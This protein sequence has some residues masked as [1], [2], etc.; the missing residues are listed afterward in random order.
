MNLQPPS[1]CAFVSGDWRFVHMR[2]LMCFLLH[3]RLFTPHATSNESLLAR[4]GAAE[5]AW[6]VW[7]DLV[8]LASFKIWLK[9]V[10]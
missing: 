7:S 1:I 5:Y 3:M 6:I 9:M 8:V 2:D 4:K 10:P